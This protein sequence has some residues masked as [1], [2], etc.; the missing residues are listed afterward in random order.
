VVIADLLA[1]RE[2]TGV[3]EGWSEGVG[4]AIGDLTETFTVSDGSGPLK[5]KTFTMINLRPIVGILYAVERK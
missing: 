4:T 5:L 3:A 2:S 1:G